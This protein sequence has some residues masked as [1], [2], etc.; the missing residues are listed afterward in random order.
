M[1]P[2]PSN[3]KDSHK[4]DSRMEALK[5]VS[6]MRFL[7]RW[8]WSLG[9][10]ICCFFAMCRNKPE[11]YAKLAEGQEPK[12]S[13]QIRNQDI[14]HVFRFWCGGCAKSACI[15]CFCAVVVFWCVGDDD[16]MCRL[17]CVPYNA[18]WS[19]SW[20]SFHCEECCQH[21]S[22]LWRIGMWTSSLKPTCAFSFSRWAQSNVRSILK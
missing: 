8:L 4:F 6:W 17:S 11:L 1:S 21:G 2:T 13:L 20:W 5:W 10:A 12:V 3:S 15:D 22:T 14:P 18:P 19:W 9:Y 16:N 7:C